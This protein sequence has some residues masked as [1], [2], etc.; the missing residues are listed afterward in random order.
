MFLCLRRFTRVWSQPLLKSL[1]FPIYS[2]TTGQATEQTLT[3]KPE[4]FGV[5]LRMDLIHNTFHYYRLLGVKSSKRTQRRVDKVGSKKK[6]R[7]QKGSGHARAGFRYAPRMKG[8]VKAHGPVPMDFSFKMNKKVVLQALKT[9]IAAKLYEK[10]MVIV[11]GY[12]AE[13]KKT[14]QAAQALEAFGQKSLLIHGEDFSSDFMLATRNLLYFN[15]ITTQQVDVLN[16]IKA[17]KI[18]ITADGIL[19]LQE[20]LLKNHQKLFMNRKLYRKVKE[21]G[22]KEEVIEKVV[23][24]TP[25]LKDVIKK[26]ELDIETA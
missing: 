7:A 1:T 5:P 14:K 17:P 18:L 19:S 13:I 22:V 12:P 8:G 4:V 15:K 9:T 20:C 16:L 24:K 11:D 23:V 6:Y 25:I 26:Y 2:F 3:L 10:T 21:E